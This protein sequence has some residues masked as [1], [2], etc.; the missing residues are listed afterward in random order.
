MELTKNVGEN[1]RKIRLIAGI[2]IMLWG[3]FAQSWLGLDR[4]VLFVT[5]FMR[6]CPAYSVMKMDTSRRNRSP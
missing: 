4:L 2:V 1:D 6:T 5:A 3:V